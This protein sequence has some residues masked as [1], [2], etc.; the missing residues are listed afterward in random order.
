MNV[1]YKQQVSRK[2]PDSIRV[3]GRAATEGHE[4]ASALKKAYF[5]QL[6]NVQRTTQVDLEAV[7]VGSSDMVVDEGPPSEAE[8]LK[9]LSRLK[10][11]KAAGVC[12]IYA[13]MLRHGGAAAVHAIP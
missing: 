12:D 5:C 7:F 11:H 13:E 2:M 9:V 1:E 8:T 4:E 10:R 3:A 6:L